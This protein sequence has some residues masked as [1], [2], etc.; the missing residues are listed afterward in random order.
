MGN[1]NHSMGNENHTMGNEAVGGPLVVSNLFYYKTKFYLSALLKEM[2]IYIGVR[3]LVS[4]LL[5]ECV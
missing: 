1:E 2:C 3:I 4:S 5:C